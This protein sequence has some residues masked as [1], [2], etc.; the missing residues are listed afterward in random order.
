MRR[1]INSAV[2]MFTFFWNNFDVNRHALIPIR[3]PCSLR[4]PYGAWRALPV[5]HLRKTAFE[6]GFAR[7]WRNKTAIPSPLSRTPLMVEALAGDHNYRLNEK[8]ETV[9]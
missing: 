5:G 8:R 2:L 7:S 9:M 6:V 4:F 1:S 3:S